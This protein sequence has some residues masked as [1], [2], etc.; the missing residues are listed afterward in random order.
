MREVAINT[1][2]IGIFSTAGGKFQDVVGTLWAM[3]ELSCAS[4]HIQCMALLGVGGG[5]ISDRAKFRL[6]PPNRKKNN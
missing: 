3:A 5:P 1:F 4:I 6:A 2:Q